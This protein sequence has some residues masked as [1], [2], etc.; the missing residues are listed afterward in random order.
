MTESE[1]LREILLVDDDADY[2]ELTRTRL[3]S[4]GYQ[5]VCASSGQEALSLLEKDLEPSLIIMDLDMPEKNGLTTLINLAIRRKIKK[6]SKKIPVVV[7]TGLR[8]EQIRQTVQAQE[9]SGYLRKPFGCDELI[10]TV[11]DLIG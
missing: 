4:F 7:A 5:V 3:E 10:K 11:K 9:V 1:N 8:S 2:C 6:E